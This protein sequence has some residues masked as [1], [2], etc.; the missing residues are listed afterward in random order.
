VKSK[1]CK[2]YNNRNKLSE[3]NL[4]K[5]EKHKNKVEKEWR[6]LKYSVNSENISKNNEETTDN[7]VR[8]KQLATRKTRKQDD[9][10]KTSKLQH[11]HRPPQCQLT[12]NKTDSNNLKE[13]SKNS[14]KQGKSIIPARRRFL[15]NSFYGSL[16]KTDSTTE[17]G[18]LDNTYKNTI[19]KTRTYANVNLTY[20]NTYTKNPTSTKN[21]LTT[22]NKS[23]YISNSKIED[24]LNLTKI[25]GQC[26]GQIITLQIKVMA[27]KIIWIHNLITS[28][29]PEPKLAPKIMWIFVS[30]E[31]K[32]KLAP[33]TFWITTLVESALAPLKYKQV[34]KNILIH[35]FAVKHEI[36]PNIN[37]IHNFTVRL[38]IAPK[39]TWIH[40]CAVKINL[41]NLTLIPSH[42]ELII[43][44]MKLESNPLLNHYSIKHKQVPKN[45]LIHNFTVKLEIASNINW[46]HNFTIRL[47]ITQK[48]T[49]IH[50][51]AVKNNL[52]N[53]TL[54]TY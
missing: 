10:T 35:N 19:I 8:I 28:A 20:I 24:K 46:I 18:S 14:A 50:N 51:C 38:E 32:L 25:K 16:N 31:L 1:K 30:A 45:I 9:D 13:A 2:A 15:S 37:W 4:Q 54:I 42:I 48:T 21:Y 43:A 41:A 40:N 5:P 23:C 49:W 12:A 17:L 11:Q 52:A 39:I 27:P 6:S 26:Q 53:L 33:R 7:N 47:E 44:R 22:T 34:P 29:E 3:K 36:A